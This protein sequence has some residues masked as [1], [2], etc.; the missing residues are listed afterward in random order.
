VAADGGRQFWDRVRL[1]GLREV[2]LVLYRDNP[3]LRTALERTLRLRPAGVLVSLVLI[4]SPAADLT[5][6][7]HWAA[8]VADDLRQVYRV[9]VWNEPNAH[10]FWPHPRG[11][12]IPERAAAYARLLNDTTL[13]IRRVRP[14]VFVSG[15]GLAASHEPVQFLAAALEAGARP[16]SLS[17][18]LYPG[19]PADGIQG[20]LVLKRRLSRLVPGK[21]LYLDEYGWSAGPDC[22]EPRQAALY[23]DLLAELAP[24]RRMKCA[25]V[26]RLED[27]EGWRAGP[28]RAGGSR[29]PSWQILRTAAVP[30]RVA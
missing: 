6:F 21:S 5:G 18:H 24:D 17:F 28:H 16:D 27:G 20:A 1:L 7:P 10:T 29:R 11:G 13:A 8:S 23:R 2:R 19:S 9:I 3:A 26:Y 14:R 15:F 4:D 30:S 12:T 22:P 25:L